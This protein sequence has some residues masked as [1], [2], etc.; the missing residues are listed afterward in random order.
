LHG[1]SEARIDALAVDENSAGAASSLIAPLLRAKEVQVL[2]QEIEKRCPNI[3]LRL[4]FAV[5]DNPA[6]ENSLSEANGVNAQM[7]NLLH[8][9]MPKRDEARAR[10]IRWNSAQ[11][12]GAEAPML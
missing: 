12:A 6:H 2:A 7:G 3:H 1:E 9:S 4:H 11:F 5:I 8:P 10:N